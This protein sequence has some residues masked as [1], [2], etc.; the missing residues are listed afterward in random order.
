MLREIQEGFF[1]DL[2]NVFKKGVIKGAAIETYKNDIKKIV[3]DISKEGNNAKG[4]DKVIAQLKKIIFDGDDNSE[5]REYTYYSV[6]GE[7]YNSLIKN[8]I[9]KGIARQILGLDQQDLRQIN[10]M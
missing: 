3:D 8:G 1:G 9:N 5:R 7:I 10:N 4:Y 6:V 2:K